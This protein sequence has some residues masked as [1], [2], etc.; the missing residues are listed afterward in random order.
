MMMSSIFLV[1][2]NQVMTSCFSSWG[3]NTAK[4]TSNT[5]P[6]WSF[7]K[8]EPWPPVVISPE[9]CLTGSA[10]SVG[11]HVIEWVNFMNENSSSWAVDRRWDHL[12]EWR[13]PPLDLLSYTRQPRLAPVLM[14]PINVHYGHKHGVAVTWMMTIH[15]NISLSNAQNKQSSIVSNMGK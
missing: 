7:W 2:I 6:G 8:E 9:C 11:R 12:I 15:F 5:Y 13:I 4:Q 1:L 10:A 3:C 14:N